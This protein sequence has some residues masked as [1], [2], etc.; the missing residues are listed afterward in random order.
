MVE[1]PPPII[2]IS[3]HVRAHHDDVYAPVAKIG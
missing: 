2:M 1:A 3:T